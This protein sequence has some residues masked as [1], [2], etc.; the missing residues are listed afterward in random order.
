MLLLYYEIAVYL[1]YHFRFYRQIS[2]LGTTYQFR[3][4]HLPIFPTRPKPSQQ[5]EWSF[6]RWMYKDDFQR[7]RQSCFDL[8]KISSVCLIGYQPSKNS[9]LLKRL[10]L[11][12][13]D[14]CTDQHKSEYRVYSTKWSAHFFRMSSVTV[15]YALKP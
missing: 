13:S 15:L 7:H 6:C 9:L 3:V 14:K 10:Y 11:Y 8:I 2:K 12:F 5:H 1:F 4:V